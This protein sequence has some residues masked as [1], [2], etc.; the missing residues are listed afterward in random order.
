MHI[1]TL[2][3]AMTVSVAVVVRVAVVGAAVVEHKDTNQ[4]DQQ[5]QHRHQQQSVRV[6]MRRVEQAL[7]CV[8]CTSVACN[9]VPQW[10]P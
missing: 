7:R 1:I 8:S 10:P 5:S 9:D 2:V 6:Y 3:T 4:I